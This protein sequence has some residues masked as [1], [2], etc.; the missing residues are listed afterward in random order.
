MHF[1]QLP[2]NTLYFRF[3]T[4]LNRT[5]YNNLS[6]FFLYNYSLFNIRI[7][8]RYTLYVLKRVELKSTHE[9]NTPLEFSI[10][11]TMC[12]I[13]CI[14]SKIKSLLLYGRYSS[15]SSESPQKVRSSENVQ[16]FPKI[17]T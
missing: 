2:F 16:H 4:F 12:H 15:Y 10:K 6:L 14:F 7:S 11:I 5:L 3:G 13:S 1:Y 17:R 9:V 8:L